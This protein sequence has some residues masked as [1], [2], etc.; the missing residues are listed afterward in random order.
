[1]L[2]EDAETFITTVHRQND[3][4]I[5]DHILSTAFVLLHFAPTNLTEATNKSGVLNTHKWIGRGG[6]LFD[7]SKIISSSV[8]YVVT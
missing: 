1:M 3:N 6:R 4:M 7:T 5:S 8:Y 2:M